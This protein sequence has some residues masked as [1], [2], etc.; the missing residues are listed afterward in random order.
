[1]KFLREQCGLVKRLPG[2][3]TEN[4]GDLFARWRD[5]ID[6]SVL[7]PPFH[8]THLD[9]HADLGQGDGGY[10][11]LLTSLLF[12]PPENRAHPKVDGQR[13]LTDGNWLLFAIGCR[14]V[15]D[16]IYVYGEGGGSD[17]PNHVMQGFTQGA[18]RIQLAAMGKQ[19][20]NK[21]VPY[22]KSPPRIDHLEPEVSYRSCAAGDFEAEAPYDFVCL[23]RSPPYTPRTADPLYE[24][25]ID[26]F[27]EPIRVADS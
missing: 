27:I 19:E 26:A 17:E 24:Q 7:E 21:V 12:E 9:A 23:T 1:M 2:V 15:A 18:D 25:I 11:Y 8:V 20:L 13:G 14:W 16:L 3:V 22:L 6:G 4:H 10:V 5:A